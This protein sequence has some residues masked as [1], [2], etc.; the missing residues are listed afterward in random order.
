MST[1]TEV[2]L[3]YSNLISGQ[4]WSGNTKVFCLTNNNSIPSRELFNKYYHGFTNNEELSSFR[5]SDNKSL[6][7]T[8][9][10]SSVGPLV[11]C[12]SD[13]PALDV[14]GVLGVHEGKFGT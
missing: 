4:D 3:V 9:P 12:L 10:S 2:T 7:L 8:G 11:R 5:S 13:N 1:G 6:L 14:T